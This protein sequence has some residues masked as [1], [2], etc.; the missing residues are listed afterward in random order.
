MFYKATAIVSRGQKNSTSDT[1]VFRL[2]Y[3]VAEPK[4]G[5]AYVA[6]TPYIFSA[7]VK[8]NLSSFLT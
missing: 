1:F 4:I 2:S 5:V 7:L 8:S 3:K 6:N